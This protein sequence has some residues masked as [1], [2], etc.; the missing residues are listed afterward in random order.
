MLND[1]RG[2]SIITNLLYVYNIY[3]VD[4]NQQPLKKYSYLEYHQLTAT[5]SFKI[6]QE[7]HHKEPKDGQ[8]YP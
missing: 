1:D 4:N 6:G 5:Q 8:K 2:T 7:Q 3:A